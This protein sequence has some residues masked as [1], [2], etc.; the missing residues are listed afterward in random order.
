[1]KWD[2][3]NKLTVLFLEFLLLI[4]FLLVY[5]LILYY[6]YCINHTT[7]LNEPMFMFKYNNTSKHFIQVKPTDSILNVGKGAVLV[8]VK[9]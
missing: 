2:L 1:M 6:S 4:F 7:P 5:L 3:I 8:I 9:I